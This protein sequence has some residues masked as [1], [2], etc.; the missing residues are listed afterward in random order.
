MIT[1]QNKFEPVNNRHIYDALYSTLVYLKPKY[2]LEI[3]TF[4]GQSAEVFQAYF[5]EYCQDG[6]LIT[7]D[8][9]KYVDFAHCPNV[10]QVIVHPHIT[11]SAEWH[12]VKNNELLPPTRDPMD[13]V[14]IVRELFKDK[15]DFCFLD[16]DHQEISVY[17]DFLMAGELLL[18]PKYIL[19]DDIDE[20]DKTIKRK[21][22]SV[23]IYEQEIKNNEA[24]NIYDFADWGIWVGAA[25]LWEKK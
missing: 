4:Y 5:N 3:G 19:F 1:R 9:K 18:N 23:R 21:H 12:Y 6:K 7:C 22:D 24:L 20:P 14:D 13:N 10:T 11:N 17:D 8:I 2:C 16:G 25:L 15:F